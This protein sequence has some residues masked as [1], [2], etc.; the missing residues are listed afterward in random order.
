MVTFIYCGTSYVL[1]DS[2]SFTLALVLK[3]SGIY[4]ITFWDWL[5]FSIYIGV[6]AHVCVYVCV[7]ELLAKA[8]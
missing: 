1:H 4:K 6:C 5:L 8:T 2:F 3:E 7:C